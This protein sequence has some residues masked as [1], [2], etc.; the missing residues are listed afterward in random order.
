MEAAF[1]TNATASAAVVACFVFAVGVSSLVWG[2]F[3]DLLGRKVTYL[4]ST[5]MFA[6]A[7]MGCIFAQNIQMMLVFRALQG[8]ACEFAQVDIVNGLL[9]CRNTSVMTE[10]A[11]PAAGSQAG[12]A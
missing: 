10:A 8:A 2:P 4:A 1:H 3:C 7:T 6:A 12:A 5:A 9:E 11:G